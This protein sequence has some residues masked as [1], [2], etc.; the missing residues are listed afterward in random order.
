[1]HPSRGC[2][3]LRVIILLLLADAIDKLLEALLRRGVIAAK[4]VPYLLRERQS[5]Y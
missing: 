5:S 4:L 2:T 3:Y 1:M